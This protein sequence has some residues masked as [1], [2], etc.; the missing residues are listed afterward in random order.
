[1]KR[2]TLLIALVTG[3]APVLAIAAEGG[4]GGGGGGTAAPAAEAAG[5]LDNALQRQ[6]MIAWVLNED[7]A[8]KKALNFLGA[9]QAHEQAIRSLHQCQNCHGGVTWDTLV[10]TSALAAL[11][12]Q[13]PWIGVSVGPADGVLRS[14]LRLPEGT[15]VVV[16]R[17]VPDGPA[18]QAGVE[19]HDV[20]LSVDGKPVAGGD[21]LDKV[22]QSARAD[23][24]PL[25]L[26]LLRRGRTL[27]KQVTPRASNATEW[28]STLATAPSEPVYR[29]GIQASDPDETLK[30]QLGL[31]GRG[32]VVT[33]VIG[34]KPADAAGVKSGDILL[35][36]SGQP[37][38]DHGQLPA[39]IQ[40]SGG[41]PVELELM[42]GGVTLK[43]TVTPAK[44]QDGSRHAHLYLSKHFGLQPDQTRELM[45]VHP[46]YAE[47]LANHLRPATRPAATQPSTPAERLRHITEQMAALQRE[48]AALQAE[49]A[50]QPDPKPKE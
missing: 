30:R 6:A 20:L 44:E 23:G 37:V 15:G 42:R 48:M 11:R 10:G 47:V 25:T 16:T 49:L 41:S 50:K 36:V 28:L 40:A 1:M 18:Q 24:T 22:L 38:A 21:D 14:Q 3:L 32:V 2:T 35:S 12:P 29:I 26:K 43:I 34:G 27:E 46:Q 19:E 8:Q 31:E 45:L 33:E 4:S 5:A 17:L 39:R 9:H 7:D 13:G